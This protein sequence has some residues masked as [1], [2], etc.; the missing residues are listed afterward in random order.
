MDRHNLRY[1]PVTLVPAWDC[2]L[3]SRRVRIAD[4]ALAPSMEMERATPNPAQFDAL[5]GRY[6]VL[7]FLAAQNT[8]DIIRDGDRLY[9]SGEEDTSGELFP[10]YRQRDLRSRGRTLRVE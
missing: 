9:A 8:L 4:V 5:S 6:L 2:L 7:G 10:S 1:G 3:F